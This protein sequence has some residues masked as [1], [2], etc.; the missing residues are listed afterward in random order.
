M[1]A[2][3]LAAL[4]EL[5][6][7]VVGEEIARVL[8]ERDRAKSKDGWL[9]L[10]AAGDVAGVHPDTVARWIR[11]GRIRAGKAGRHVR[12]R[13]ADIERLIENGGK[14]GRPERRLSPEA[15]ADLDFPR[16][17]RAG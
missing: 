6:R 4:R 14:V 17:K 5:V 16:K 11:E 7:E 9:S 8:D 10:R 12:V 2:E 1:S 15:R 13:R 3:L